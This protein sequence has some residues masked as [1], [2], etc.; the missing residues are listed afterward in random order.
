[1]IFLGFFGLIYLG[2]IIYFAISAIFILR[3]RAFAHKS[4]SHGITS[5]EYQRQRADEKS[6]HFDLREI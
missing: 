3:I 1:M 6:H 2:T 5:T 4:L